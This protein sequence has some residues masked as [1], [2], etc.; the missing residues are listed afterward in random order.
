MASGCGV[1]GKAGVQV[2]HWGWV[3]RVRDQKKSP[4]S[5][6]YAATCSAVRGGPSVLVRVGGVLGGGGAGGFGDAGNETLDQFDGAFHEP[7]R[8]TQP[9][10][11]VPLP[12]RW[13]EGGRRPGGFR[14]TVGKSLWPGNSG[15]LLEVIQFSGVGSPAWASV[16]KPRAGAF[17]F[18]E[19][20]FAIAFNSAGVR[21]GR[22]AK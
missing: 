4:T 19:E 17:S 10:H 8:A 7:R 6:T 12:I 21:K 18:R 14:E 2:E 16:R 20:Y 5:L 3:G 9:P 15:G 13:G 11:P 1:E 22:I